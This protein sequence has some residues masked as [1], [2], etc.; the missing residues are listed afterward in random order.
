[1]QFVFTTVVHA[2][3]HRKNIYGVSSFPCHFF[4]ESPKLQKNTLR[5]AQRLI[6]FDYDSNSLYMHILFLSKRVHSQISRVFLGE[7]I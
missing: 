5:A 7:C 3:S 2:I 1:M 4:I 6:N